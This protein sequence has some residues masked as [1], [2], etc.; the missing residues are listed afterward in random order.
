MYLGI[1]G[2]PNFYFVCFNSG[3]LLF[4]LL[5]EK[6]ALTETKSI[7]ATPNGKKSIKLTLDID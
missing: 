7:I 1:G 3:E 4:R 6:S 5:L 2:M